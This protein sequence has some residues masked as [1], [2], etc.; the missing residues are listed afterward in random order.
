MKSGPEQRSLKACPSI[1]FTV[2]MV[3]KVQRSKALV[4]SD[5]A[6]NFTATVVLTDRNL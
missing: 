1:G 4:I 6:L 2:G 3:H 5:T